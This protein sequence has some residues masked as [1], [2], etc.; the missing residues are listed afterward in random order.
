MARISKIARLP[1]SV[2]NELN[3]RLDNGEL[4]VAILDWL[5]GL[6][7]VQR[8]LGIAHGGRPV[9][10]QNLSDWRNGGFQDWKRNQDACDWASRLSCRAGRI[11]DE[12]GLMPL[13]DSVASIA[14]LALGKRLEELTEVSL[15]DQ[16]AREEF[17]VLLKELTR[18]RLND[19]KSAR[20]RMSL[21]IFEK[22][23]GSAA[24]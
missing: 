21:Q 10:E 18:I 23:H 4:G 7:E 16:A 5:N 2:R 13:S 8:A 17:L 3:R 14:T 9:T 11:A 12:A 15:S 19:R 22:D 1:R 6:E 20:L 24:L